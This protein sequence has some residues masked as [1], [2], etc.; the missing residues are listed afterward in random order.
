MSTS[1]NA[2]N[3][4][5][6]SMSF[7]TNIVEE[8]TERERRKKN[9]I[10]FNF[11]ET[12]P[13]NRAAEIKAFTDFCKTAFSLDVNVTKVAR[14]GKKSDDKFRPLLVG[15]DSIDTKHTILVNSPRLKTIEGY[16]DIFISPDLTK[17]EKEKQRELRVELKRRREAGETGL[18]IRGGSIVSI[19]KKTRRENSVSTLD[20][21]PTVS[22]N[23]T[24]SMDCS[25]ASNDNNSCS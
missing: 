5:S 11:Q 23:N 3:F 4:Q 2:Y 1:G 25:S 17:A 8:I 7:A 9:L 16:T 6:P 22:S 12:S 10:V 14:L 13:F 24:Q 20:L 18:V 15:L 19:N 21:P